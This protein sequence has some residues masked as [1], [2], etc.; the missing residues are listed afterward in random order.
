MKTENH[1]ASLFC[2][3]L[4]LTEIPQALHKR[5]LLVIKK[6]LLYFALKRFDCFSKPSS[7]QKAVPTADCSRLLS[8]TSHMCVT[9]TQQ[10]LLWLSHRKF[11]LH[12]ALQQLFCPLLIGG[13]RTC[14]TRLVDILPMSGDA[15]V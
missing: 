1:C 6:L 8:H 7:P 14:T 10:F 15:K 13:F 5:A 12:F 2:A 3:A 4:T 9:R 11:F